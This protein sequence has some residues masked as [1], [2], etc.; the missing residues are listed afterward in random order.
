MDFTAPRSFLS[1]Y[2]FN[3]FDALFSGAFQSVISRCLVIGGK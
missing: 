2:R 3:V 1:P